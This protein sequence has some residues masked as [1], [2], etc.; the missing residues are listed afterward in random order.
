MV[1]VGLPTIVSRIVLEVLKRFSN[2]PTNVLR[3][4]TL[5]FE[6]SFSLTPSLFLPL[7]YIRHTYPFDTKKNAC[8]LFPPFGMNNR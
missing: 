4:P 5:L 3:I 2:F 6:K 1:G 7:L 8:R